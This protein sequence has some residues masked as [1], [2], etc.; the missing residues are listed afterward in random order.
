MKAVA[1]SEFGSVDVLEL[2]E[3]EDPMVRPGEVRVKVKAAGVLPFDC[4]VRSGW[5]PPMQAVQF[6]QVLGNEF[7]G[8]VDQVG[9][10]VTK[11]DVGDEVL[12]FTLM[13]SYAEYVLATPEQIVRKPKNMPWEIAGGFSGNGQGA[14][15]A[16]QALKVKEG[17][18]VLIHAAAGGLGTFAVQLAKEWGAKTVIGT[19][20]E[21]N[22]AYLC[23]LGAI[24]VQYGAGLV[25]RVREIAPEGVD[26]ALDASG[27]EALLASVGLVK[28]KERIRTM[29][30]VELAQK[31]QIPP[32]SGTRSGERLAELVDLYAKGKLNIHIRKAYRLD[33]AASAHATVESGHGRG[34]VVLII[35]EMLMD[36]M[37]FFKKSH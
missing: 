23:E 29:V 35:D 26:A 2:I 16:L 19:A 27:P 22:H 11:F 18:T 25:D 8:I 3:L 20:S 17:D 9:K 1:F 31:L 30:A 37:N 12:G 7:A 4:K 15:M 13:K 36:Q 10:G 34:K 24:P 21:Q 6:P 32:I 33:E 28:D 5:N 14:H